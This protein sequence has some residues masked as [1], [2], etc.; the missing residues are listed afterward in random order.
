MTNCDKK[1]KLYLLS[2]ITLDDYDIDDT[3]LSPFQKVQHV[4]DIFNSEYGWHVQQHGNIVSSIREW[5]QG[6]PS[7]LNIVFYNYDIIQ[8]AVS[9]GEL[10]AT[11]TE[12]QQD[13][14]VNNYFNLL[15]N[16]LHQLFTA[17]EHTVNKLVNPSVK[18]PKQYTR[19]TK[20]EYQLHI[21]YG[22][23]QGWEHELSEDTHKEINQRV[24][25]YR[26]NCPEYPVKVVVKRVK[27]GAA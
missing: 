9:W 13:K 4:K 24:R 23:G 12:K 16:K 2:V 20:D 22:Y 11:A 5:L 1:A 21:N 26:E 3:N 27:V 14:I 8:L 18:S 17:K 15:A 6:L 25:E 10:S 19:K 7:C